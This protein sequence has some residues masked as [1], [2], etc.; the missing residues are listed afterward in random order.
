MRI[1]IFQIN[2]DKD[3]EKVKFRAL[4]EV[5]V[6]DPKIYKNVYHGDV[7]AESLEQIYSMFNDN[8]PPT[9]Q[10]H[11]LS[12]SDIVQICDSEGNDIENGCYYC[13]TIGFKSLEFDTSEC[14]DMSGMRVVY[15]TPGHTPLDIRI[16]SD[17]RSL[18]NAV[19]G[20]IEP[21]YSEPEGIVLVGNDEAKLRN[22]KGN[23]HIGSSSI[24]AGPFFVCGDTGEDFTS[25]TNEQVDEYMQKFAQPEDISDAEVQ[26][27]T[28]FTIHFF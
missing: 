25:L 1:K 28:G 7:D 5:E 22:M 8:R 15:V 17:L 12:M 14:E 4:N 20:L 23:R 2:T 24:I 6:V 19:D 16:L 27:D 13:D 9:F 18:Q 11:S 26:Q 21:I 3:T 10:G